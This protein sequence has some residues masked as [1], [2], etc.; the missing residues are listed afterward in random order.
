MSERLEAAQ[1]AVEVILSKIGAPP[2]IGLIL[3]SGLGVLGDEIERPVIIDY[4]DI[5]GFPVSTVPGHAGRLVVGELEGR[6]VLVM[7]GRFHFYEGYGFDQVTFPV[8]AMKVMGIENL[9]VTN[10]AGGVNMAFH[11]ADLMLITDHIKFFVDSP[12]RGKNIDELGPRF[13]DMSEAYSRKLRDLAKKVASEKGIDL[14]EGVYAFMG[15]P[16][17]E[18][19]AEIRMLRTLGADAVGMSTVPEVI[20]AAHAGMKVLGISCISNMAAGILPQPLNHKEV[21]ETGELVKEKFLSLVR[22]IIRAWL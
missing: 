16:S 18:T 13:N 4:K 1:K 9:L 21:M 12:L 17:F 10:A 2:E 19:P 14:R 11:P 3:G 8:L 7:Q 22:G 5:P 6:R 15:G 20:T